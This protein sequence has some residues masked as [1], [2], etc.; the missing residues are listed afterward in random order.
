MKRVI[1]K[2]DRCDKD[3]DIDHKV[4]NP[5]MTIKELQAVCRACHKSVTNYVT[6][7]NRNNPSIKPRKSRRQLVY[8]NI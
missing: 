8:N 6:I 1:F 5:M 2:I 7:K 3:Y 4:Y